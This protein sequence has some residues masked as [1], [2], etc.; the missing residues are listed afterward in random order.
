MRVVF[1]SDASSIIGSGHLMRCKTLADELRERGAEVLFICREHCGNLISLLREAGYVTIVLPMPSNGDVMPPDDAGCDSWLGVTQSVDAAQTLEALGD[2]MP[3]WLIVDHYG[4][5]VTWERLLRPKVGRI[6]V[7]DDLANRK[8]DCDFLLDQNAYEDQASRYHGKIPS[9]CTGL[10]GPRYVLLRQEFQIAKHQLKR[11]QRPIKRVLVAFGGTDKI[12]TFAV[13]NVLAKPNFSSLEVDVV[14]GFRHPE[15]NEIFAMCA[16]HTEWHLHCGT[17]EMAMLMA[18]ADIAIGAGGITTW[19]RIYLG[20]PAFVKAVAP[21]QV[22]ALDHLACLGQVKIWRD[23]GELADLLTKYLTMGLFLPPFDIHFGTNE[24][25]ERIL[26]CTKLMPFGVNHVRRTYKWLSNPLL[27]EIFLFATPPTIKGH[28]RYWRSEFASPTQAV[29]SIYFRGKH[30]GNCGLK[31]IVPDESRAELWIYLGEG[32]ERGRGVGEAALGLLE[33][34]AKKIIPHGKLYL[35]VGKGN[36][37]AIAL[38]QKA[39][40]EQTDS[41]IAEKWGAR[42]SEMLCMEKRW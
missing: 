36:G 30:V 3:D 29:F 37:A 24:I 40:F 22:E 26:P 27:R 35:H 13:L 28:C 39:G 31:Y 10:F 6:F 12:E 38:Y 5:D 42:L 25:A 17:K 16:R 32:V 20:L 8:H 34:E 18:R 14:I 9:L 41:P 21:N 23:A 19:E 4:L 15:K 2:A 33:G 1:R 7:I 11:L